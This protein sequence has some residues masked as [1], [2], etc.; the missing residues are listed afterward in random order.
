MFQELFVFRNRSIRPNTTRRKPPRHSSG[1]GGLVVVDDDEDYGFTSAPQQAKPVFDLQ[2]DFP[3]LFTPVV[4][5]KA[6]ITRTL[7]PVVP[8]GG[9]QVGW[10]VGLE[11][12]V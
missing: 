6:T 7:P 9:G 11:H 4:E 12:Y 2:R 5:K 10:F 3:E 1:R 8:R